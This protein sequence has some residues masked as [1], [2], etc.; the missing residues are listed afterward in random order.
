[1]E[2][3]GNYDKIAG[4]H[5]GFAGVATLCGTV[6]WVQLYVKRASPMGFAELI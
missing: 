5:H 1:M 4:S 6:P 2:L 3:S